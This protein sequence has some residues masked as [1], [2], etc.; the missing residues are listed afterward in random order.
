MEGE[1][2]PFPARQDNKDPFEHVLVISRTPSGEYYFGS[3]T[4]DIETLL[5]MVSAFVEEM[6]ELEGDG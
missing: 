3:T 6:E 2:L 4:W 1:I 5:D